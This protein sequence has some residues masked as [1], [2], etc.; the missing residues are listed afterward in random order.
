MD[1]K[2]HFQVATAGGSVFDEM[3]SYVSAPLADGDAGFMAGHAPMLAALKEGVIKC[4]FDDE[5]KYIA[6]SGGVLSVA[7]NELIILAR[8]AELGEN[9]DILRAREA[10]TRARQHL[11]RKSEDLDYKRAELALHRAQV[12]EKA[13]ALSHK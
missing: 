1:N 7:N 6:I 3:V 4:T 2:I 11:E 12:R 13:Y 9:I 5:T 8:S 10:E